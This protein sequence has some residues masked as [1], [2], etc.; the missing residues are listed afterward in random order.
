[1]LYLSVRVQ[2]NPELIAE[3]MV[4]MVSIVWVSKEYSGLG[5]V[6][7]DALF[8]KHSALKADTKWSVINA[9]LYA[10]CFT[11]TLRDVA[12]CKVCWATSHKTK[13]CSYPARADSTIEFCV[14]T[15]RTPCRHC[16]NN[17]ANRHACDCPVRYAGNSI[18]KAAYISIVS[19]LTS[20]W[21]VGSLSRNTIPVKLKAR[22]QSGTTDLNAA[23]AILNE[24]RPLDHEL[25]IDYCKTI[26]VGS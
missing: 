17:A 26:I 19:M 16:Y 23:Q 11:G 10:R 24:G 20:V 9:T 15:S 21:P 4:Y 5:W 3:L 1:M 13:D 14:Q 6:Q 22:I 8:R 18:T 7:Y 2:H 25:H 12:R